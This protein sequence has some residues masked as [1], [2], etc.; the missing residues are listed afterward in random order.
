MINANDEN[1]KVPI[2]KTAQD[3]RVWV[4]SLN[5]EDI[6]KWT[7][8]DWNNMYQRLF[9]YIEYSPEMYKLF[10]QKFDE[11]KRSDRIK[12]NTEIKM[13]SDEENFYLRAEVF[14]DNIE[15]KKSLGY[16]YSNYRPEAYQT[17]IIIKNARLAGKNVAKTGVV[18]LAKMVY[19][20]NIYAENNEA[21]QEKIKNISKKEIQNTA[22]IIN[23]VVYNQT[24]FRKN[25]KKRKINPRE[26]QA[27]FSF[28]EAKDEDSKKGNTAYTNTLPLVQINSIGNEK[29]LETLFHEFAHAHLQRIKSFQNKKLNFLKKIK[30]LYK[31]DDEYYQL[32]ENNNKLYINYRQTEN[33]DYKAYKNQPIEWFAFL[34]GMV[35]DRAF[36]LES[37]QLSERGLFEAIGALNYVNYAFSFP[38]TIEY[39]KD[40][41]IKLTWNKI[42]VQECNSNKD[43]VMFLDSL[44]N[45][46]DSP[47]KSFVDIDIE[48][49]TGDIYIKFPNNCDIKEKW[50]KWADFAIKHI[51]DVIDAL[52]PNIVASIDD[53]DGRKECKISY[54]NLAVSA[55]E[56]NEELGRHISKET[57]SKL[58][59]Y[60]KDN[61]VVINIPSPSSKEYNELMSVLKTKKNGWLEELCFSENK[62]KAQKKKLILNKEIDY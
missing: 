22:K 55:L 15:N 5:E 14:L 23:E 1:I 48:N 33:I 54:E 28:F 17:K 39:D 43:V 49:K 9:H 50:Y 57:L 4:S 29:T 10:L 30:P 41:K 20:S 62:E 12:E 56:I 34:Y 25:L 59:I 32:I 11:Y 26:L 40:K 31:L 58:N 24:S 38:D 51:T 37:N 2:F 42:E 60:N 7:S 61:L 13:L 21:Y 3:F 53:M 44:I 8:K 36:R 35:A 18:D 16:L 47:L 27:N 45:K 46:E 6:K 52:S 19:S